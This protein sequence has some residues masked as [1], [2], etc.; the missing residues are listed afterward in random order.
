MLKSLINLFSSAKPVSLS[1]EK[2]LQPVCLFLSFSITFGS[3][4]F[5]AASARSPE[6]R[7][8]TASSEFPRFTPANDIFLLGSSPQRQQL[9]QVYMIV[10]IKGNRVIGAMF[11]PFSVFDCFRGVVHQNQLALNLTESY[12]Q[13]TTAYSLNLTDSRVASSQNPTP[14]RSFQVE[15]LYSIETIT[16]NDLRI[17]NTCEANYAQAPTP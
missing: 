6:E 14:D 13:E 15:G 7:S 2:T 8:Q 10:K 12:T 9:G 16:D 11:S 1:W 5:S 17:L 3:L 4:A